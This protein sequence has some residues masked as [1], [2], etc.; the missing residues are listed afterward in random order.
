MDWEGSHF[1]S[2]KCGRLFSRYYISGKL[3]HI[4]PEKQQDISYK[5]NGS[6]HME[7]MVQEVGIL[8]KIGI[9][10]WMSLPNTPIL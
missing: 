3:E 4:Y 9:V 2:W 1:F 10:H 6:K 7:G 8:D 5:D